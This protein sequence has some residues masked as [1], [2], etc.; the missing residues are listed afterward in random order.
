[1]QVYEFSQLDIFYCRQQQKIVAVHE[2]YH[3]TYRE[4]KALWDLRAFQKIGGHPNGEK[5]LA[6]KKASSLAI[7]IHL[8]ICYCI[9]NSELQCQ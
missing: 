1:M 5:N 9:I 6:Y 7:L 3:I 2:I 8:E 4:K